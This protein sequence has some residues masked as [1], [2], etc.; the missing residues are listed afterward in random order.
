MMGAAAVEGH[1][2]G[3]TDIAPTGEH[4]FDGPDGLSLDLKTR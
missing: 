2:A 1:T 4:D 3:A